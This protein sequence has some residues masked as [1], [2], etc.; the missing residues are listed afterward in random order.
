VPL[1][2][3]ANA[4]LIEV[5]VTVPL[6]TV[7]HAAV[8]HCVLVG[9]VQG[10]GVVSPSGRV[11][12]SPA[13]VQLIARLGERIPDHAC[14]K[15]GDESKKKMSNNLVIVW[16]PRLGEHTKPNHFLI[17][18]WPVCAWAADGISKGDKIHIGRDPA[19]FIFSTTP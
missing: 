18:E 8:T 16:A 19:R 13:P 5:A 4:A 2:A 11:G 17:T 6:D 7:L 14:P 3:E 12:G 1:E 10:F 15:Q 9:G